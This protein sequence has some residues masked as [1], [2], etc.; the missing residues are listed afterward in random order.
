LFPFIIV[1]EKK[2]PY[3]CKAPGC[4]KRYTDPSSLR[5]HVKTVHGADFYAKRK[6]KGTGDSGSG[7]DGNG[8][9]SPATNEDN[10]SIK[11]TS[12]MSPSIK[13]E[14]DINSPGYPQM[15]SPSGVSHMNSDMTDDYDYA[16]NNNNNGTHNV[17]N[18]NNANSTQIGI[19]SS[20]VDSQWPYEEEEETAEV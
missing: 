20:T 1:T 9:S 19:V 14:S 13:S 11:T 7:E 2:K 16:P 18:M 17:T 6:H 3:V 5:K 8:V 12:L 4:T 10:Y 15:N